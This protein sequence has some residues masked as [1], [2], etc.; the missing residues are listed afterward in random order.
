MRRY[1][2]FGV[3]MLYNIYRNSMT[4][5]QNLIGKKSKMLLGHLRSQF[6]HVCTLPLLGSSGVRCWDPHLVPEWCPV[7]V[8]Y[9]TLT[10]HAGHSIP[11]MS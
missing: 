7:V 6:E 9:H 8:S 1:G 2:C 4:T 3:D 5:R 11:W 10:I